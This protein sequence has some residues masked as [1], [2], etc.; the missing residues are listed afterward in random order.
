MNIIS[1]S[2]GVTIPLEDVFHSELLK[3][4][5]PLEDVNVPEFVGKYL[6]DVVAILRYLTTHGETIDSLSPKDPRLVDM[7]VQCVPSLQTPHDQFKQSLEILKVVQFLDI[8]LGVR[9]MFCFIF[10]TIRSCST[11][12]DVVDLIFYPGEFEQ[13]SL[14]EQR[15]SY[16]FLLDNIGKLK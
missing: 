1:G 8:S 2:T 15:K 6:D 13:L 4:M 7:C 11:I 3:T 12:D 16:E 5:D 9:L 14:D 10:H